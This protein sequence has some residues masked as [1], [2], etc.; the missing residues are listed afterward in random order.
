MLFRSRLQL[1]ERSFGVRLL[2]RSPHALKLTE[3][4]ERCLDHARA[5]LEAWSAAQADL[6]GAKEVPRGTLRVFA[7]HAF[8]QEQMVAPLVDF[9]AEY[10]QVSVDWL[11]QD[12]SPDFIADGVDCAIR[13]GALDNDASLVAVHL[14]EVP[15]IVVAA[16]SLIGAEAAATAQPAQLATL[17][18]LALRMYY[19]NEVALQHEASGRRERFPIRPRLATDSLLALRRAALA[20]AG[21]ALVSAWV[22][23]GD[24]AEGTL[25]HVAPEWSAES[26]PV[27]LVYP[28]A[29]FYP[30]RLRA[31]VALMRERMPRMQGLR[32]PRA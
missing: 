16:P 4:G 22:V 3:D 8:G 2:Q 27:N 28:Y 29:R 17:P 15:R 13:V 18:W 6:R 25:R 32:P 5:L 23:A 19:R 11:L 9:L 1:L 12:R 7:P 31:F 21:A 20:G 26:L 14:A 10:P 24:L 30:A